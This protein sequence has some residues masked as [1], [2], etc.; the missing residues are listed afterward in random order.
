MFYLK[1]LTVSILLRHILSSNKENN[2]Q[3][4]SLAL[5]EVLGFWFYP[6]PQNP[7]TPKPVKNLNFI[8]TYKNINYNNILN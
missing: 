6:K 4:I 7:K 2:L 5:S 3:R 1:S 8:I